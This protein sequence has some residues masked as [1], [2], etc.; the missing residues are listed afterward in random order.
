MSTPIVSAAPGF[1]APTEGYELKQ[2]Y[3]DSNARPYLVRLGLTQEAIRDRKLDLSNKE[4]NRLRNQVD[5]ITA[6]NTE[7]Q[8]QLQKGDTVD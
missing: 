8:E 4:L 3:G 7:V 5:D 2:N 6:F 1:A